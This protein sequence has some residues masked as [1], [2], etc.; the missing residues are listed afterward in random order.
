MR[1]SIIAD[2]FPKTMAGKMVKKPSVPRIWALRIA[3]GVIAVYGAYA[4]AM[5]D[6]G[7]YMTLREQFV[8][9]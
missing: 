6:V 7:R 1:A 4:F 3:E 2:V 8:F 9:F 5:R